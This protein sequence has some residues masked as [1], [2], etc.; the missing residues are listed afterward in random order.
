MV[1]EGMFLKAI[2]GD[3]YYKGKVCKVVNLSNS[4]FR[5]KFPNRG[6]EGLWVSVYNKLGVYPSADP[7]N[8]LICQLDYID[9][10]SKLLVGVL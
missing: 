10:L 7:R 6:V 1:F 4:G 5:A 9:N 8:R 3:L 2:E